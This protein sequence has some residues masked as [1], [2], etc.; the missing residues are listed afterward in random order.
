MKPLDLIATAKDL[1]LTAKGSPSEASLRR[2]TST[3]YYA[4]FH[5]LARDCADLLIGEDPGSRSDSAWKQVY[6]ALQHGFARGQCQK[7]K[8]MG[9]P[10]P[11]LEFA[12]NFASLQIKREEAD[13]DLSAVFVES[14]VTADIATAELAIQN[15][16]TAAEKDRRAFCVWVLLK[17]REK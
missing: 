4:L 15:Y 1:L 16:G 3:A 8:N 5:C 17:Q 12:Q 2:A 7:T 13:Y 6:R 11:I 14:A 9:F 10:Q